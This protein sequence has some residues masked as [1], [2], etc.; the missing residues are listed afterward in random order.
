MGE[1]SPSS[2]SLSSVANYLASLGLGDVGT[3]TLATLPDPTLTPRRT[4]W[5]T[6]LFVVGGRMVSEG[7]IWKAIRP[8]VAGS[9]NSAS[10]TTVPWSTPTTLLLANG[11]GL[12]ITHS[13]TLGTGSGF[14][15]PAPG[16]RQRIVQPRI[17]FL[18][19]I[20]II[21]AVTKALTGWMDYEWDGTA[22]QQTAS[23]GIL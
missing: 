4:C 11:P 1:V 12:S 21:G 7:G 10:M 15:V 14:A 6:D 19:T 13:V 23:G 3:Y 17:A 5:V 22:W 16:Y 9:M 20:N 8:L 18:G 2:L